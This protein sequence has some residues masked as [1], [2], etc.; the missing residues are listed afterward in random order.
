MRSSFC[1]K[2]L[3]PYFL[4]TEPNEHKGRLTRWFVS[5]QRQKKYSFAWFYQP[6][7]GFFFFCPSSTT[8]IKKRP[9]IYKGIR[10]VTWTSSRLTNLTHHCR[11]LDTGFRDLTVCLDKG[12]R[13]EKKAD[14]GPLLFILSLITT[15]NGLVNIILFSL[16]HCTTPRS[17]TYRK[18]RHLPQDLPGLGLEWLR[19]GKC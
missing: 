5:K 18:L 8:F 12:S 14:E 3:F 19:V 13:R 7:L 9:S 16:I 1:F 10:W 2:H 6:V 15:G 11:G 17:P 4:D